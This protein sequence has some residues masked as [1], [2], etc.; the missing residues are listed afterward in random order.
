VG[1]E[2]I[3]IRKATVEDLP[4][5]LGLERA[6]FSKAR[7]TKDQIDW[8]LKGENEE[9][10]LFFDEKD[11]VGSVMLSARGSK[12]KVV[13]I[14]V[15][16][17]WRKKGVARELMKVAEDW[18]ADSGASEVDLEV[19]VQNREALNLY[20]TLG[21]EVVKLIQGYYGGKEDAYLMRKMF[22]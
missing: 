14:G 18:F 6:C 22:Q 19:G 20:S 9:T 12:G 17:D 1:V 2:G 3:V 16:P 10:F 11:P 15:H 5:L 21:Y 7:Y 8:F 13:S 4:I